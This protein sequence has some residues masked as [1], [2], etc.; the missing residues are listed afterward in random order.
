MVN[1]NK[2]NYLAI[3]KEHI[4]ANQVSLDELAAKEILTKF[5]YLAAE[6]LLQTSV[7]AAI[8]FAKQWVKA[9]GY[10]VA[11]NA[12]DDFKI[13]QQSLNKISTEDLS[14]W[15]RIIGLRNALVHDYLNIDQ[16][17]IERILKRKQYQIIIKFITDNID[18]FNQTN[19]N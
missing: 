6:R 11:S 7:E 2:Q 4:L 3:V 13:L 14:I 10:P 5:D 8:G 12:Y 9:C 15:K 17:I 18:E 19:S 16:K 1:K